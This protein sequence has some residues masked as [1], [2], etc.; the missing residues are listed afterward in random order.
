MEN[1]N[2]DIN[3]PK[4]RVVQAV[5]DLYAQG[6]FPS[7]S[8]IQRN[9]PILLAAS[10]QF[11]SSWEWVLLAARIIRPPVDGEDE[12]FDHELCVWAHDSLTQPISRR[13]V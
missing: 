3:W 1:L 12:Y 8:Y 5:K 13:G 9:E 10:E 2:L 6:H 4:D 11:F 7:Y